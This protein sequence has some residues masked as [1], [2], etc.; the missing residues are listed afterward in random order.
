MRLGIIVVIFDP[1]PRRHCGLLY[2][3]KTSGKGVSIKS[4]MQNK[5]NLVRLKETS[6]VGELVELKI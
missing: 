6:M 3:R 5:V 4:M 1:T 2:G